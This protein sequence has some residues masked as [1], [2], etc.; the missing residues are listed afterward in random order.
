MLANV[1]ENIVKWI[2]TILAIIYS[3]VGICIAVVILIFKWLNKEPRQTRG[4]SEPTCGTCRFRSPGPDGMY[5]TG[6][7]KFGWAFDNDEACDYYEPRY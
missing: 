7:G 5:C 3:L 1:I 6:G 4:N 2:F